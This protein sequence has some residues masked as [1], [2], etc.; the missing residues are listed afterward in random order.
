MLTTIKTLKALASLGDQPAGPL[1]V[2]TEL[3][4]RQAVEAAMSEFRQQGLELVEAGDE[5]S[6]SVGSGSG[7]PRALLG[8]FLNRLIALSVGTG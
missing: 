7:N 3:Y 4:S 6:V 2:S 1:I 5:L 8:A